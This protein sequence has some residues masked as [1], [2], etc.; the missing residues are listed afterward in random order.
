[1][2]WKKSMT[3]R[4]KWKKKKTKFES[5]ILNL[6]VQVQ[7]PNAFSVSGTITPSQSR[8]GRPQYQL[9]ITAYYTKLKGLWDEL[10]GGAVKEIME[11]EEQENMSHDRYIVYNKRT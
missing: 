1:M 7:Q 10:C 5:F 4:K 6:H 8:N 9:S 3:V 2:E 11:L